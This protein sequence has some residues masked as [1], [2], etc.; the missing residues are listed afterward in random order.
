MSEYN[1]KQIGKIKSQDDANPKKGLVEESF[2]DYLKRKYSGPNNDLN[3]P[4][5]VQKI[6]VSKGRRFI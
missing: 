3:K 4:A 5:E 6:F 1:G 2:Y